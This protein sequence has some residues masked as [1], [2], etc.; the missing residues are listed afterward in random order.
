MQMRHY[1]IQEKKD[2][3]NSNVTFK[4][5][6][7]PEDTKHYHCYNVRAD[8]ELGL[9]FVAMRRIPCACE[10]CGE[11]LKQ[12]WDAKL[13]R[14][15]QPRYSKGNKKCELW[16]IFEGLNDW[17]IVELSRVPAKLAAL[18]KLAQDNLFEAKDTI[19]NGIAEDMA[20]GIKDGKIGAFSME[21]EETSGYYLVQ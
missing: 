4:A 7:L 9:A 13:E 20:E 19:L 8:W 11:Q 14:K 6:G 12:P 18:E 16:P 2:V 17:H 21:D 3:E 15:D 1:H 10:A 5:E